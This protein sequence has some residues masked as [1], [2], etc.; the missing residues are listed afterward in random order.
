MKYFVCY[1]EIFSNDDLNK[2]EVIRTEAY[3][4]T[5][6]FLT[7]KQIPNNFICEEFNQLKAFFESKEF[8]DV[9]FLSPFIINQSKLSKDMMKIVISSGESNIFNNLFQTVKNEFN[10][11]KA[12]SIIISNKYIKVN[13]ADEYL[14]KYLENPSSRLVIDLQDKEEWKILNENINN[15]VK[16]GDVNLTV[17]YVKIKEKEVSSLEDVIKLI[18]MLAKIEINCKSQLIYN[19]LASLYQNKYYTKED[20]V[21]KIIENYTKAYNLNDGH[22]CYMLGFMYFTGQG[23]KKDEQKALAY[24]EQAAKQ[25]DPDAISG[26]GIYYLTNNDKQKAKEYLSKSASMLDYKALLLLDTDFYRK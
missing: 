1:N 18:N 17:L 14:E 23:F 19:Q 3:N 22:A 25:D 24:F 8:T 20:K 15:G 13:T 21:D 7:R 4:L 12:G 16:K 2:R 11:I 10:Q 26:L 6:K 5:I 9:Y